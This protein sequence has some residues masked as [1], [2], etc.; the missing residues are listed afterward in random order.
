MLRTKVLQLARKNDWK[1]IAI[2]SPD[3]GAGKTTVAANLGLSF[4]RMRE[5]RV[6]VLDFDMRRATL[7]RVLGQ[8]PKRSMADVLERRIPFAEHGVCLDGNVAFGLNRERV[9][10]PSELLQNPESR[11]ALDE[12]ETLY[13]PDLMFFD[14]TPMMVS[15]DSHGFLE[16]VDAALLVVGAERTPMERIDVAERQLAELTNVM[17]IV[18][19]QCRY[20]AGAHGYENHYY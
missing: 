16:S 3:S 19:N 1:R 6:I 11:A 18:L 14:T 17:G 15:D 2:V 9:I 12:I 7:A 5:K 4:S 8:K 13:Q 20:T 10:N